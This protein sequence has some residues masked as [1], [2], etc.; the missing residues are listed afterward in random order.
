MEKQSNFKTEPSLTEDQNK[1]ILDLLNKSNNEDK[2]KK[3]NDLTEAQ[4]NSILDLLN[5]PGKEESLQK[6]TDLTDA[7]KNSILDIL[8]KQDKT[9]SDIS[10]EEKQ[11]DII[12]KEETKE[13]QKKIYKAGIVDLSKLAE[14]QAKDVADSRMTESKEDRSKNWIL[15]TAKRFWKHN[16]AQEWYRN[17]EVQRVRNEIMESG[18]L[19]AGETKDTG[20]KDY[21]NAKAA[22]LDRFTSEYEDEVL[23]QEEKDS[24]KYITDEKAKTAIKDL[25]KQFAGDPSMSEDAFREEQNRILST[26]NPE[27]TEKGKMYANNLLDIAKEIRNSVSHGEKLA[28]MDFDVEITLG[29]AQESLNTQAKHNSFEKIIEKT[30]NSKLGRYLFNEPA[31]VAIAAGLYS[32]GNFLG[33]KLLRS[34][35]MKWG[36]FG[37]TAIL[38][39]GISASKEAARLNRER[40]Q[41]IRESSKGMEFKESDMKRRKE[42]EENRYESK[43]A[44]DIIQNF[45]NDLAK[46]SAGNV[47]ENE[48]DAILLN[49]SDLEARIK[50]GDTEKI[51]LITYSRFNKVEEESEKIRSYKAKIKVAIRKGIEDGRIDFGKEGT[52]D[53]HLKKLIDVQSEGIT[54]DIEEKNEIF[55]SM[56]RRKVAW[57]FAKTALIGATV[58]VVFQ[59]ARAFFQ[60]DTDGFFE[61]IVRHLRGGEEKVTGKTTAVEA[62]SRWVSNESNVLPFGKGHEMIFGN[63]HMQIPEG[64]SIVQN[65]D[66]TFNVLRGTEIISN[67]VKMDLTPSGDLTDESKE[68]LSKDNIITSFAQ[69]GGKVTEQVTTSAQEYINKHPEL[70]T[71]IDRQFMG[72]NTEMYDDPNNPGHLLGADEN[73]LRTQWGGENGKGID[74]NGNYVLS[75]QHMTNDGSYQDGLPSV[76]A[77]DEMKKGGLT[78]LLSVT[79][80]LQHMVFKV[81]IDANG[82]AIIDPKSTI[83]QMMFQ[84]DGGKAVFTGQFAEI[85]H[86][87]GIAKDGDEIMQILGTHIGT[88][89]P[90][91]VVED[92][93]R[94]TTTPNVKLDILSD[95]E[96]PP[97]IPMGARRPLERGAYSEEKEETPAFTYY[98]DH[99]GYNG[100][101]SPK[102]NKEK[103]EFFEKNRCLTLK[104]NPNAKLDH[105]KEI[106]TYLNKLD[107]KYR[108]RI[109]KLAKQT[110]KMEKECKLAA[111]IPVAG[112]Q[113]GKQIYESL[114][115]YTYQT[116]KREDFEIILFVNHPEKDK[117]GNTLNATETLSEIDRFKNDHPE[118]KLRVM[119]EV[120]SN[121]EARI[122]LIRKML[123][124]ATLIR[125]HE[126][127]ESASDLIMISSDADNK[128]VDPRYI[129][130]FIDNFEKN[131]E[132]DGLL[133]QLDWDPESYQKYPAIHIGTRLFQYLSAIGRHRS[134]RMVSSG[135]NSA[136]RSSIYAGIGGYMDGKEGGEDVAIGEAIVAARGGNRN[137]FAFAGTETRL[138]TSSRRAISVLL[139]YGLA[140]VEQWDKGFSVH[141]DKIRKLEMAEGEKIDYENPKKLA[142]LKKSLESVINRTLDVYEKDQN[143]GKDSNFY[144][145]AIGWMGIK[146]SLDNKGNVVITDMSSLV[147]G[148]KNYQIEGKLIRDARAGKKEAIDELKS[149]RNSKKE[150][151]KEIKKTNSEELEKAVEHFIDEL[152][153][154]KQK[155]DALN[156]ILSKS[157]S[158]EVLLKLGLNTSVNEIKRKLEQCKKIDNGADFIKE[159]KKIL[160]P[161]SIAM[162][163]HPEEFANFKRKVFNETHNFTPVNEVFSY[164]VDEGDLHIH[165][166]PSSDLNAISKVRLIKDALEKLPEIIKSNKKIKNISATSWIVASNPGLLEKIGFKIEGPI[167]EETRKTDF[168]GETAPISRATISREE[169]LEKYLKEKDG[170]VKKLMNLWRFNSKK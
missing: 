117:Q 26:S 79:K 47:T 46:I 17:R 140:P 77:H 28:E 63:T 20:M 71:K 111:C 128:G 31:G 163:S 19:Y 22:I 88:G 109:E 104:E 72:N 170:F 99:Y 150:N 36:T 93:I 114:E 40:A 24:K 107:S 51:D 70:T 55:K 89:R 132:A 126:R 37:A 149:L 120:L 82:N 14:A 123:S 161:V 25:M 154:N 12:K 127:G 78:L 66:G 143:L 16:V 48:L 15:R 108:E 146:Y 2:T 168:E 159:V 73:E 54:T 144:K 131:P 10:K 29:Q 121:E 56:K 134:N 83:G 92:I 125:Q 60:S 53:N 9:K 32:A 157:I 162:D 97:F 81:P 34:K 158:N 95:Y 94:D 155:I 122:G 145:K 151:N 76:D 5:K 135:A 68:I 164:R 103:L 3:E 129:Q 167:S 52:F 1:S 39:G 74:A 105:Y 57:A 59:E 115:N 64:V 85:A 84:N 18:N 33:V 21:E 119:Y 49:L 101:G 4:K 87:N 153:D 165:M 133:G 69:T 142:E 112:H 130:A 41:H 6:E 13:P 67:N 80:G 11:E 50:L 138:F 35:L 116:A 42:M 139:E 8:N 102:D 124:D 65:P 7:Q 58:G 30:Q 44:S 100:G 90:G 61:G 106:E 45:E 91:E 27:Y 152:P 43:N 118:I 38:A 86:A 160:S 23:K 110:E 141:D 137:S 169:F 148:L 113:E 75:V 156:K 98:M 62:F 96:V 166:A 136:Y 147:K